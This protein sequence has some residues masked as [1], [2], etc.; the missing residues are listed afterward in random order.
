MRTVECSKG[1]SLEPGSQLEE[2]KALEISP[3]SQHSSELEKRLDP[4]KPV[5]EVREADQG[6]PSTLQESPRARAEAVFLHEVVRWTHCLIPPVE[7]SLSQW[8]SEQLKAVCFYF[9]RTS[10]CQRDFGRQSSNQGLESFSVD[11]SEGL[12]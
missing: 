7:S 12:W 9:F 10:F 6:E 8:F 4:E 11:F 5:E 3:G 1:L 2:K